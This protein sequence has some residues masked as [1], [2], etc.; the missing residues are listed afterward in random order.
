MADVELHEYIA[1]Q[2]RQGVAAEVLRQ[3]LMEAGWTELE[4]ENAFHDVA[5]GLSP[6]TEG[7]SLHEDV[8]QVRSMV[9]LLAARLKTVEAALA[10]VGALPMQAELPVG[11]PA[12]PAGRHGAR[13]YAYLGAVFALAATWLSLKAYLG[14]YGHIATVGI[15]TAIGL[16]SISVGYIMLRR[17]R[18]W[19]AAIYSAIA[20][21][22]WGAEAWVA[23][24]VYG[25]MEWTTA[26][27]LAILLLVL[28]VVTGRRIGRLA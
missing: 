25:A 26:L 14:W 8:S 3:S 18:S 17:G 23:W 22:A 27:A 21:V 6:L 16:F 24:Y 15:V 12:L 7:A 1:D 11:M 28:G 10:S 19:A 20:L 13:L 2:T 9:T 5:A 4:I